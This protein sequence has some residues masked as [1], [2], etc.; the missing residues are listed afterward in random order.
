MSHESG[1]EFHGAFSACIKTSFVDAQ[2][3]KTNIYFSSKAFCFK[4]KILDSNNLA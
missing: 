3:N 4:S 2:E 1:K